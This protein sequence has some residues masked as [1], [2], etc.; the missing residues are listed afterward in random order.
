MTEHDEK[1]NQ[2]A[3]ACAKHL[4]ERDVSFLAKVIH[5]SA[6]AWARLISVYAGTCVS[7][8]DFAA[9][10]LRLAKQIDARKVKKA[11]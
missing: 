1:L 8:A 6:D 9:L 3:R 2:L 5:E 7:E 10:A 4:S 11:D